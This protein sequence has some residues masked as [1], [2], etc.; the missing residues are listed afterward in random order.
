MTIALPVKTRCPMRRFMNDGSIACVP[1][2]RTGVA[3]CALRYR[4]HGAG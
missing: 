4:E 2:L 3:Y 1:G